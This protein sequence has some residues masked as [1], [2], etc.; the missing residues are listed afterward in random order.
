MREDAKSSGKLEGGLNTTC[1]KFGNPAPRFEGL[2][3]QNP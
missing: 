2:I 3:K 1:V